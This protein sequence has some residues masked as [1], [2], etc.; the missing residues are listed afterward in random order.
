MADSSFFHYQ[1]P[2]RLG[3]FL[4]RALASDSRKHGH[5]INVVGTHSALAISLKFALNNSSQFNKL[6][7]LIVVPSLEDAKRIKSSLLF[8]SSKIRCHIL[9]G[10]DV[11]PY[12][13]LYPSP[14]VVKDR[15]GFFYW[16]DFLEKKPALGIHHIFIATINGLIQKRFM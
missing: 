16:A 6:N 4:E 15:C 5:V 2:S 13:G 12:M 1:Q 3:R 10:F 9:D 7:S 8:F 11:S 14:H